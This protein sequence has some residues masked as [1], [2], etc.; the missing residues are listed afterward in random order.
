MPHASQFSDGTIILVY[1]SLSVIQSKVDAQNLNETREQVL[2]CI[3]QCSSERKCFSILLLFCEFTINLTA[4]RSNFGGDRSF[5][6]Q[7]GNC[8]GLFTPTHS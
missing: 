8:H 3:L 4:C 6:T 2:D 7:V 5:L 1:L